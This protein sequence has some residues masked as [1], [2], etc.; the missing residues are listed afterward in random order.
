MTSAQIENVVPDAVDLFTTAHRLDPYPGYRRLREAPSLTDIRLGD[1]EV[2]VLSRFA[3]CAAVLQSA[4]WGHGNADRLSPFWDQEASLP[5]SFIRMDPPDHRRLR[6]LVNKAFSARMVADLT[7]MITRLVDTLVDRAVEAGGLDVVRDL[8]APLALAMV[9]QRLLG[10]PEQDADQLRAWE[11][12]IARGTDPEPLLTTEE[13]TR[14]DQAGAGVVAYL[15]DL[16]ERR[17]AHPENDLLSRLVAVEEAGDKL[18]AAEVIGI[19]VLL[20]VAGMET[21]INLVGNGILAL[22]DHPD[23]LQLLRQRPELT[24]PA[25][26]EILRYDTPTQFTMR[27]A[28]ADTTIGDRGFRRGDGVIV[29][30]GSADRDA[31]VFTEPDRLDVTRYAPT[32]RASRHLGFSLGLHYCMGAPLARLEASSAIRTLLE[33]APGLRLATDEP[34]S[35]QP[36][37]IHR[38]LVSLPVELTPAAA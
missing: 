19:C 18:S 15:M 25:V 7:P 6:G 34:L 5:G 21:S 3:D 35:Y 26:E 31:E 24:G 29:L 4:T 16:M 2:T 27:V 36:S 10:V 9:G 28:L 13:I 30:M 17:R 11:L 23:Q 8:S 14:R 12:A 32:G 38:G 22:L 1:T 33:R 20:L 37:V